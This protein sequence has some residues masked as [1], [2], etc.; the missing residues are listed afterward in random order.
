MRILFRRAILFFLLTLLLSAAALAEVQMN[1]ESGFYFTPQQLVITSTDGKAA[2]YFTIDGT[3]P[4]ETSQRFTAPI[5][6][7]TTVGKHDPLSLIPDT[8]TAEDFVPARDFPSAHVIRAVAITPE[9]KRSEV[10]TGT[11]FIGYDREELYGS[12]PI[13]SLVMDPADLFDSARGIYVLGDCFAAWDAEQTAPYE[14]WQT[15]GNFSQRGRA[16]EREVSV[17]LLDADG[18]GFSQIMGVR[19]KGGTSRTFEQKSLRLIARE[20]YGLKN[21]KYPLFPGNQ[22]EETGEELEKYKSFTLRNGGNDCDFAKIRDPFIQDLAAGM[23]FETAANRPVVAF[24]NGEYWGLYTLTEEYSDNYIDYHYGIDNK[25]V[26]TFK[27]NEVKDGEESDADLYWDMYSFIEENDM[28]DPALYEKASQMLDMGSFADYVALTLYIRNEDGLFQ[29]NNWEMWRVR[30]PDPSLHPYA[31]GKWRMMLYDTDYSSGIYS[32]GQSY[33]DSDLEVTLATLPDERQ[34]NSLVFSL[35]DSEAFRQEL[36]RSLCDL[37]NLFFAPNRV[38]AHLKETVAV[39][40]AQ[41]K[42]TYQRFGPSWVAQWSLDTHF[43]D[44]TNE[45]LTF[46]K[47]RASYFPTSIRNAF[48]LSNPVTIYVQTDGPG[49]VRMNE[50]PVELTGMTSH[51]VFAGMTMSLQAIPQEG[52]RFLGWRLDSGDVDLAEAQAETVE[53]LVKEGFKITAVFE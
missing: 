22:C 35:L 10:V 44:K 2:I 38:E 33:R 3:L 30:E 46:F 34:P 50:R 41:M 37:R 8:T 24:L 23:R 27:T 26:V 42:E 12:L 45:L 4:D 52:S 21:V 7:G 43:R 36:I 53:V 1:L 18:E 28:S 31:D 25:N 9:G 32:G 6:L 19:I 20:D 11:Y 48:D 29:G 16:W 51:K 39:Y 14:D 15:Q 49:T 47:G 13:M 40:Q 17:T 5:E